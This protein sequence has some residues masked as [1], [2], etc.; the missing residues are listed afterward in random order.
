MLFKN[1]VDVILGGHPHVVQPMEK[2][3]I[4]LEDGTTKDGF[5]IYSLG[6]FISGQRDLDTKSSAILN[7]AITKNGETGKISIDEASYIPVYMYRAPN[8]GKLQR[9]KLIDIESNIQKYEDGTDTSIGK[10]LYNTLKES[11]DFT[12][13]VLGDDIISTETNSDEI[14]SQEIE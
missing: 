5:V 7:L 1:G 6:N 4:T 3:E 14:T 9:F 10:T 2:R 13:K 11:L 12:T 8:T